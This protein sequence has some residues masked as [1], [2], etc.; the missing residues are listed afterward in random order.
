MSRVLRFEPVAEALRRV[1]EMVDDP[2]RLLAA[3][4]DVL[5][6]IRRAF[7]HADDDLRQ[8]M[9]LA[10]TAVLDADKAASWLLELMRDAEL[11][12]WLREQVAAHLARFASRADDVEG[13][14]DQILAELGSADPDLR[15]LAARALGWPGNVLAM[16]ALVDKLFDDDQEVRVAAVGSLAKLEED[17]LFRLLADRM[18]RAGRAERRAILFHL[19]EFPERRAEVAAIYRREIAAAKDDPEARLEAFASL[20]LVGE[21][22]AQLDDIRAAL[23]DPSPKLRRAALLRLQDYLSDECDGVWP[24]ELGDL[25]A[26]AA[27]LGG[28]PDGDPDAEVR[29]LAR[30]LA[31]PVRSG[32]AALD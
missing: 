18:E 6:R 9:L 21:A 2:E 27:R 5:A 25:R 28:D 8:R 13:I 22:G 26:A 3:G 16:G 23:D 14:V 15:R 11:D 7:P 10:L 17:G 31:Q 12:G 20:R 4:D 30:G 29:E 24:E 1:R 32:P 19:S